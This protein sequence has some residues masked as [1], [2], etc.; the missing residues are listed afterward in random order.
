METLI[1]IF[2]L[3]HEAGHKEIATE[4]LVAIGQEYGIIPRN[5]YKSLSEITL[6]TPIS[7]SNRI[8]A[9]KELRE[10][11]LENGIPSGLA[12]C[13]DEIDRRVREKSISI[14]TPTF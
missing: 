10:R 4:A 11:A 6:Y 12:D 3:A 8:T 1:K 13:K 2:K 5:R 7:M 14:N 9:I